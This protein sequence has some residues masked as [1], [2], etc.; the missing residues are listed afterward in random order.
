MTL[1]TKSEILPIAF[2]AL[3]NRALSLWSYL[4]FLSPSFSDTLAPLLFFEKAKV[5]SSQ[6]FSFCFFWLQL[7]FLKATRLIYNLFQVFALSTSSQNAWQ[8]YLYDPS[9][10]YHLLL[11][12]LSFVSFHNPYPHI[13]WGNLFMSLSPF[14]SIESETHEAGIHYCYCP[15]YFYYCIYSIYSEGFN[16][17]WTN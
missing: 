4:L 5:L 2:S 11:D 12:L 1:K 7:F 10:N 13:L 16:I 9:Y 17:W 6:G 8:W 3:N 14:P 15:Y